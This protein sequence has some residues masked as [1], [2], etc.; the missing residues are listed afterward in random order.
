MCTICV[1]TWK[2]QINVAMEL[3]IKPMV[4]L[5]NYSYPHSLRSF[6]NPKPLKEQQQIYQS[7]RELYYN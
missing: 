3:T 6:F 1:F 2:M 5:W 7:L 4:S